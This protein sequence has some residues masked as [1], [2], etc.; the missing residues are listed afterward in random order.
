[1]SRYD[2]LRDRV[3]DGSLFFVPPL[4]LEGEILVRKLYVSPAI[5]KLLEGPWSTFE[6]ETRCTELYADLHT[7]V[8]GHWIAGRM[9]PSKSTEAFIALLDPQSAEV[10]EIRSIDAL[11]QLRIFGRFAGV[12]CFVALTWHCR[13]ELGDD[14]KVWAVAIAECQREWARLLSY[15]PH[16]GED[17]YDYISSKIYPV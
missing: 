7:F 5:Y 6:W 2:E 16:T 15:E 12:D 9:P 1:M 11:P 10:W 17:I 4:D 3:K 14:P 8:A 13:P